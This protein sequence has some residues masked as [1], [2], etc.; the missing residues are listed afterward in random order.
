MMADKICNFK[1]HD[2]GD[3]PIKPNGAGFCFF[4]LFFLLFM[5]PF[6]AYAACSNPVGA[7]GEQV[8]NDDHNVMQ[9]CDGSDWT[10]MRAT[11]KLDESGGIMTGALTLSGAPTANDHAATKE[12]VDTSVAGASSGGS[13]SPYSCP[14]MPVCTS[15]NISTVSVCQVPGDDAGFPL[16]VHREDLSAT[17]MMWASYSGGSSSILVGGDLGGGALQACNNLGA[18]WYLPSRDELN[19]L[20]VQ[21]TA[22]GNF[23]NASYWSSTEGTDSRAWY[24][25]F[26]HGGQNNYSKSTNFYVRCVRRD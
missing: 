7:E 20:Y 18:G 1:L 17:G 5:T 21:R 15:G 13:S 24:Q 9:Y 3:C 11:T 14:D 19:A 25:S 26:S 12:Y 6:S 8:Y 4:A 22:I 23:A 10:A 16:C 2:G